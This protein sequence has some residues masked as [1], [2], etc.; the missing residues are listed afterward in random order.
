MAR[1][2]SWGA[3]PQV[4]DESNGEWE[5]EREQLRGLLS[6]DEWAAARRTTLN[7]HYTDPAYVREIWT[8]V[9][10]LGLTAGEVL[11]PGAGSGTFIGMAPAGVK[12]TGI[13]L[14]PISATIARGL[15]PEAAV[16]TESFADTR[17]PR[18]VADAVVGN[19]PFGDIVLHDPEFNPGRHSM[20]NYF[21]I[22][23]LALTRPGG[24]VA[25]LTS[26]YTM[27]ATNPAARREMNAMGDLVGAVRL[28]TGAH[29]RAAGTEAVTDLVILR[30]RMPGEPKRD[31]SWETVTPV[32]SMPAGQDQHL[33]ATEP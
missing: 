27:D 23:A 3:I 15:Y 10:G 12:M 5:N 29:Q 7:A 9:A 8:A 11:E 16:R 22:K 2:S 13:E 25:V 33:L 32:P 26:R 18:G 17:L 21:I 1:W 4:F 28:P 19:V 6:A 24:V 30:R 20:H 14:D 31:T